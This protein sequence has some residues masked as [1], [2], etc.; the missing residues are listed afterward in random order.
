MTPYM[1]KSTCD[2]DDCIRSLSARRLL[3]THKWIM[4]IKKFFAKKGKSYGE[5]GAGNF[6][7]TARCSTFSLR[8]A[9]SDRVLGSNSLPPVRRPRSH[10]GGSTYTQHPG[11]GS[12]SIEAFAIGQHSDMLIKCAGLLSNEFSFFFF[13]FFFNSYMFSK[14]LPR[15]GSF[16]HKFDFC[17]FSRCLSRKIL[18]SYN[19]FFP[20]NLPRIGLFSYGFFFIFFFMFFKMVKKKILVFA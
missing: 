16:S 3:Y 13:F 11:V 8:R 6:R 18:L 17:R 15:K 9:G 4:K 14:C 1:H 12:I 5:C 2:S 20:K 7:R 10:P 19:F